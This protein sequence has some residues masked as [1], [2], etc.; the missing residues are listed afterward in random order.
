MNVK[1]CVNV[2]ERQ[3]SM[4]SC[5]NDRPQGRSYGEGGTFPHKFS[6]PPGAPHKKNHAYIFFSLQIS[7]VS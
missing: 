1:Y 6:V 2:C 3:V 5:F 7:R 4:M